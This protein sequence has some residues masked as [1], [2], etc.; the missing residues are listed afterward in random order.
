MAGGAVTTIIRG[1]SPPELQAWLDRRRRLGQDRRDEVWEG[2]YV[3]APD[4]DSRHGELQAELAALLKPVARRLG[5]RRTTT[6]NL[7]TSNDF[8]I[9]DAGLLP[10]PLGVW[11]DTAVVVVEVLS[12][13][14]DTFAKLDFYTAHGVQELLVADWHTRTIRCFAMQEGQQQRDRSEVLEA[15]MSELEASVDWPPLD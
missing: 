4:P 6:F 8:R 1:T 7:G 14:D 11:H 2:R 15:T 13:E 9:P 3:V 10:G 12:P 5:L